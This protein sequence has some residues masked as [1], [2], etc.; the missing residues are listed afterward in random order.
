MQVR[1]HALRRGEIHSGGTEQGQP[2]SE[3]CASATQ[4]T[5]TTFMQVVGVAGVEPAT[6][7]L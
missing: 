2:L 7:R 1:W 5:Q 4:S 3:R 6:F